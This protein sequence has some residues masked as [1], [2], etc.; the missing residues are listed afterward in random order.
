MGS[1]GHKVKKMGVLGAASTDAAVAIVTNSSF[2]S[3]TVP[4]Q[5]IL[6][7]VNHLREKARTQRQFKWVVR[8]NTGHP[9]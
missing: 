5:T 3:S 8:A 7:A 4:L 1:N 2:K 9:V 6:L